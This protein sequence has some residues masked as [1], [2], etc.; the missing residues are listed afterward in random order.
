MLTLRKLTVIGVFL[1]ALAPSAYLAWTLRSMPH[2]GF[3]HDDSIYLVSA[4]SLAIGDGYRIESLP[5]QPYQTKYPPLYSAMLAGVWKIDPRFPENLPLATLFAWLMLPV[6][7]ATVWILLR[8]YGF[9]LPERCVFVALAALS[10]VTVVFSFSLMPEL[11]FT[12]LFIASLV[13][14]TRAGK[15]EASRWLALAAGICAGLAYLTKS[16]AA[17]MLVTVPFCFVLRKQFQKAALFLAAMLPAAAG[18]QWWVTRHLSNSWDLVTLYYT[19]YLGFRTYNISFQD[20]PLLVWYNLDGFLQGI[21]KLLI[22]DLPYGSKHL[23]RIVAI[24]AIA[25]C[26]RL[27]MRRREWQYPLAALGISA[28]LLIWHY[29]PDQ[30]FVFP[31][32]PFFLMGIATEIYNLCGVLRLAWAK[33][34][35]ADRFVAA[36]FGGMLAALGVF[37][38]FCTAYGLTS[39]LPDLFNSH[40]TDFAA[41]E[42]AYQWIDRNVPRDANVY[43]YEDPVLF[44]YTGRKACGFPIP[45]KFYYHGDDA[46]INSLMASMPAFARSHRLDY[47]LLTPDDYFKDLNAIGKRGLTQAMQSGAFEKLYDSSRAAVYKLNSPDTSAS[48]QSGL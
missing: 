36:G 38:I 12:A 15:P 30:R 9:N 11:P 14:A 27:T 33:P 41:R 8:D 26:V 45:P 5:G 28:L 2:L 48:L 18:W 32:Y 35:F 4:R 47:V 42:K 39:F 40:R 13:L 16:V 31:L 29:P 21:G 43:A 23:E 1:A 17:P 3:Y 20:L 22:F 19:N 10:P 6:F 46:A 7:L 34:A 25:G 44:L 37:A 24:A